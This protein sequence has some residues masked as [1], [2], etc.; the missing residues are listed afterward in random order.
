MLKSRKELDAEL[1]GTARAWLD[2][3]LAE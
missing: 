3:A 1:D 2:G